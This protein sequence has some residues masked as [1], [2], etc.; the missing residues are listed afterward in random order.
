LLV[1]VDEDAAGRYLDD[2]AAKGFNAVI[3]NVIEHV[4]APDP[5]RTVDGVEPFEVPGDLSTP[6]DLYFARLDRLVAA[7][8]ERSI[9]LFL[10]PAYLGYPD[11]NYPGFDRRPEGWFAELLENG[12][13]RCR[14]YGRYLGQRYGQAP[15][16]V[17][18][19]A[20]DRR[21][22]EA[23]E[24]VRAIAAGLR[25]G[26]AQQL[27][28]AHVEPEFPPIEQFPDDLWLELNQTYSYEIVHRHLVADYLRT[29][30][31]PFVLFESTYEGEHNASDVQIRR[32]AYWALLSGACGQFLGN[33]PVWL[34]PPGWEGALDS[35]GAIA[36]A[37]LGNLF[38]ARRWWDLVPDL[39]HRL[40]IAGI[41]ELR[42]LD[43]CAASATLDGALA[44]VYLPTAR[45]ITV[46][47]TRLQPPLVS[48]TW[49]EPANGVRVAAGVL[50]TRSAT[51][52]VP[53][54][55]ADAVLVLEAPTGGLDSGSAS[56]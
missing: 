32:Q 53:P 55:Q 34:L 51:V 33:F 27:M 25:A 49:V 43:T 6:N 56:R 20:G 47:L 46:D 14:S 50:P 40:V 19:M 26:R 23:I 48:A 44:I 42:G 24:H 15:N 37:H 7:A 4:F 10:A 8:A 18:V 11:P 12:V 5:P 31:R 36:M 22:G 30:V 2:R 29:P 17:W 9:V 28:T 52:F 21:P 3:V 41:G 1:S 38:R 45:P 13:E 39:D 16:I 54:F 35:P